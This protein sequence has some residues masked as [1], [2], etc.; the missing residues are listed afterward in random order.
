MALT[1]IEP[2]PGLDARRRRRAHRAGPVAVAVRTSYPSL[3]RSAGFA[4]LEQH[5]VTD[6]YRATLAAWLVALKR[7]SDEIE[8]AIGGEAHDE[9]LAI[10]R[11][12]LTAIDDGLL[13]RSIYAASRPTLT[14]RG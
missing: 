3:F 1:T 13:T 10:G 8:R 2:T 11:D 12:A 4:D 9:R 14:R 5:D 7:R 6:E